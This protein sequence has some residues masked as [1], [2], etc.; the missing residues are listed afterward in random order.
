MEDVLELLSA[1]D[2]LYAYYVGELQHDPSK[3]HVRPWFHEEW[4]DNRMIER[5]NVIVNYKQ[6]LR[7]MIDVDFEDIIFDN[8]FK[9]LKLL[10]CGDLKLLAYAITLTFNALYGRLRRNTCSDL[11]ENVLYCTTFFDLSIER[12]HRMEVMD[13]KGIRFSLINDVPVFYGESNVMEQLHARSGVIHAIEQPWVKVSMPV[14]CIPT[15]RGNGGKNA[16]LLSYN[17]EQSFSKR[18]IRISRC[19]SMMYQLTKLGQLPE[20]C[21][22]SAFC[23]YKRSKDLQDQDQLYNYGIQA[24]NARFGD[25]KH[26]LILKLHLQTNLKAMHGGGTIMGKLFYDGLIQNQKIQRKTMQNDDFVHDSCDDDYIKKLA[27]YA[28]YHMLQNGL[29][30]CQPYQ[31]R[32]DYYHRKSPFY[33]QWVLTDQRLYYKPYALR[34]VMTEASKDDNPPNETKYNENIDRKIDTPKDKRKRDEYNARE[35][36]IDHEEDCFEKTRRDLERKIS[37]NNRAKTQKRKTHHTLFTSGQFNVN[38][39]HFGRHIQQEND[40]SAGKERHI[41]NCSG[42]STYSSNGVILKDYNIPQNVVNQHYDDTKA[43]VSPCFTLASI[44]ND[45]KEENVLLHNDRI[46]QCWPYIVNTFVKEDVSPDYMNKYSTFQLD[47]SMRNQIGPNLKAYLTF[48]GEHDSRCSVTNASK[49]SLVFDHL[50]LNILYL[51]AYQFCH[52]VNEIQPKLHYM[53]RRYC[54]DYRQDSRESSSSSSDNS[55]HF[56]ESDDD[57]EIM[58]TQEQQDAFLASKTSHLINIST[59]LVSILVPF[60]T[61]DICTLCCSQCL[62]HDKHHIHPLWVQTM[63]YIMGKDRKLSS[64]TFNSPDVPKSLHAITYI[65]NS[66]GLSTINRIM[67]LGYHNYQNQTVYDIFSLYWEENNRYEANQHVLHAPVHVWR[68]LNYVD[69]CLNRE[70]SDQLLPSDEKEKVDSDS[71]DSVYL[72]NAFLCIIY[73]GF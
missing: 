45:K 50:S 29:T 70:T 46:D 1:Q 2:V 34:D 11:S 22:I 37:K 52:H 8:A 30:T 55:A 58:S 15:K 66:Q 12:L 28:M 49:K 23:E 39:K 10:C 13:R 32:N 57:D 56:I 51:V 43:Y 72:E 71:F 6:M 42:W 5:D 61:F 38:S 17:D 20:V 48:K 14:L 4:K 9:V 68:I 25:D 54:K 59:E 40:I 60:I 36:I 16:G 73:N 63:V 41:D 64:I 33:V 7:A 69:T 44:L 35:I 24:M 21:K 65:L 31:P 67:L 47:K 3:V 19:V 26:K 53:L 27:I 18:F 62:P